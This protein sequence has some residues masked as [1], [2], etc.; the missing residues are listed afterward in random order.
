[1]NKTNEVQ[2]DPRKGSS[3]NEKIMFAIWKHGIFLSDILE[4]WGRLKGTEILLRRVSLEFLFQFCYQF[5]IRPWERYFSCLDINFYM[6]NEWVEVTANL[7]DRWVVAVFCCVYLDA[8]QN[9]EWKQ[10]VLGHLQRCTR[11]SRDFKYSSAPW[12]II[13]SK[14]NF[15]WSM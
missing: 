4:K 13:V 1:M 10:L 11:N 2:S 12:A 5:A 7:L 15:I 6:Y 3:I 9:A 8:S 14:I